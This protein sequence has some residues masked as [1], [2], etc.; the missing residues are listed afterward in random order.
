RRNNVSG[1]PQEAEDVDG[2]DADGEVPGRGQLM[3]R[4]LLVALLL[5]AP[6]SVRSVPLQADAQDVRLKPDATNVRVL[7]VRGDVSVIQTPGGNITVLTFPQGV[8]LVDAGRAEDADA[9]LQ[10]IRTLS[11]QAI[12]YIINTSADPGHIG[13]NAKLAP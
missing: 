10:A 11:K 5:A 4:L 6:I 9:V 2:A 7:K 13:G 1:V 12:R 8:T 3:R